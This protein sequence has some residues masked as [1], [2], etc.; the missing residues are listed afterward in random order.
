MNEL[1]ESVAGCRKCSLGATRKNIVFGE[2]NPEA[3]ILVIGEGPGATEDETGIPFTGRSG[4]LLDKIFLSIGLNRKLLF[5]ANIVKCRPPNNRT[6][7]SAEAEI[8]GK[9]LT[10]QIEIMKPEVILT[11]GASAARYILNTKMGIGALRGDFHS[12]G[13]IPVMVTYHPAALLR[14][15]ALKRPVWEDMKKLKVFLDKACL[16]R[17]TGGGEE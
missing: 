15:P 10:R 12:Y 9:F 13:D 3:G 14:S 8:C 1:R 16:P 4:K 7:S 6:P 2:G 5:I 17:T 11:L